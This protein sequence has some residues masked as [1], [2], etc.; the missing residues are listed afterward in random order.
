MKLIIKRNQY[1]Q[2]G[3]F[4]G[5]KGMLFLLQCRAELT[6]AEESLIAKYK[7]ADQPLTYKNVGD[8]Q[9]PG[10]K[11]EDL[12][13]GVTYQ[14]KDV[15]TLLN[16]EAVIKDACQDFKNLLE[17]MGSFGGEEVVEF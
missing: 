5:H 11:I 15:T 12:V 6:P 1:A 4:G 10:L 14:V 2:K 8:T 16:N 13:N 17:V 7:A 3:M 9:I